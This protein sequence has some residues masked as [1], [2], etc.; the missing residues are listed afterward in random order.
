MKPPVPVSLIVA[1]SADAQQVGEVMQAMAGEAGFEVKITAMEFAS[2][3]QA[4]YA[5]RFEAL[6]IGWSGRVDPD[7]NM[8]QFLH[9]G[10]TFNY[11]HYSNPEMDRLL[12]EQ[13]QTSDAGQRKATHRQD[14]GAGAAG[15]AADLPLQPEEQRGDE[16]GPRRVR[17]GAGRHH[18]PAR[19]ALRAVVQS[20]LFPDL[21]PPEAHKRRIVR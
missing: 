20:A 9:T 7:G 8:Y 17:A 21:L 11:G 1:N 13:R 18:P 5:G 15:S 12:D 4:A 10:G 19:D 6:N 16:E 2:S 3:L 14:L